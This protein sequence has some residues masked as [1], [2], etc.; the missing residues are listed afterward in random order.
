MGPRPDGRG[1]L[2]SMS[3]RRVDLRASMGPRPDGRGTKQ[4]VLF[5][6]LVFI[7]SMGPRPDGRGTLKF[8][9]EWGDTGELQWGRDRM[10]AER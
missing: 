7:A 10:A 4:A 3:R 1:T 2:I 9:V 6:R 5:V 8:S